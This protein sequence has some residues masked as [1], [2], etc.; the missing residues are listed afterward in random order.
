M[1][2]KLAKSENFKSIVMDGVKVEKSGKS[3]Q[4]VV[5]PSRTSAERLSLSLWKRLSSRFSASVG[6]GIGLLQCRF[7]SLV[8]GLSAMVLA[9]VFVVCWFFRH[10]AERHHLP[11]LQFPLASD[12]AGPF[13]LRR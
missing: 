2:E 9:R 11:L 5:G 12:L 1:L 13:S 7:A 3:W 4:V 6:L 10:Q 8:L